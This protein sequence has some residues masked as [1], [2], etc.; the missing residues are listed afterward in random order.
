MIAFPPAKIN[1]G[2]SVHSKRPDGY[3][4]LE[5]VF[6]PIPFYD[7]LE[8]V[9]SRDLGLRVTGLTIPG[10]QDKNLVIRTYQLLK[11]EYPKLEPLEIHLHKKIPMGAGLGGGSA[12]AVYLLQMINELCRLDITKEKLSHFALKMGSDCPFFLQTQP[13]LASGRGE[14]LEPLSL[15][16][17][18]YS[19]LLVHP[20]IHVETARAFDRI[21][22]E[23]PEGN[24]KEII[25]QPVSE[26]KNFLHNAFET[27]VFQEYPELK[28]IKDKLYSAGASYASLTGSGS[29]IYGLFQ[30]AKPPHIPV[31]KATQTFIPGK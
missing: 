13:C 20:E 21:R 1:L 16:L 15:D 29:T 25:Q 12:D 31:E 19:I 6:Y 27:P 9:P 10:T 11:E 5:T 18:A 2:L 4:N 8:I 14:I 30:T 26:W 24:L 28:F 7:I 22:P 3:H 23:I 17:S